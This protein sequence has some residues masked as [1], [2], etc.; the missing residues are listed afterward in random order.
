MYLIVS[1]M[2]YAGFHQLQEQLRGQGFKDCTDLED[3]EE[4][5][6]CAMELRGLRVD[7]MPDDERILGF[8]NRWY[9]RA[10]ET[11]QSYA[12]TEQLSIRLVT[13]VCFMTTKLEAWKGRGKGDALGS[14]D[15]EDILNLIDGRAELFDEIRQ[16]GDDER[17][18]IAE[19][20]TK[21]HKTRSTA[22][23]FKLLP[24]VTPPES[25]ACIKSSLRSPDSTD[26]GAL[27]EP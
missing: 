19:E 6:I 18:Y 11:A 8:S 3:Q 27:V 7:F 16:A 5:P 10:V 9:K 12:L 22:M 2:G 24:E 13:P 14:R 21:V 15:M 1:V 25:V 17:H 4:M 23:H 26:A 20:L